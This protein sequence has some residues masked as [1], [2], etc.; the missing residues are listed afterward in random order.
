MNYRD[1]NIKNL[2][3]ENNKQKTIYAYENIY[4]GLITTYDI[5]KCEKHLMNK[6]PEIFDVKSLKYDR[7]TNSLLYKPR[8][9][10]KYRKN[11]FFEIKLDN[12]DNVQEIEKTV[13]NL[14]GWLITRMTVY[15]TNSK[16]SK[17]SNYSFEQDFEY[18]D[19]EFSF[20]IED[21]D[22]NYQIITLEEFLDSK[23]C[24]S[25]NYYSLLFEA[26]FTTKTTNFEELYHLTDFGNLQ[27]IKRYGLIPKTKLNYNERVYFSPNY[28]DIIEMIGDKFEIPILL[29][30]N[31]EDYKNE[32]INKYNFYEDPRMENSIYTYDTINPKYL[33]LYKNN[34]WENII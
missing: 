33:Q 9:Q 30:L 23:K 31:F 14:Y 25:V 8:H 7:N 34:N 32:I 1:Y 4:E 16:L 3:K 2:L 18:I 10:N 28:E 5:N 21:K 26:K 13:Y 22:N 15:Y 17:N 12:I 27:K 29:R 19:D 11:E 24:E 6:F 20:E